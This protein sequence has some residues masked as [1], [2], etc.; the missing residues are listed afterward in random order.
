MNEPITCSSQTLGQ[1]FNLSQRR[2]RM[3][4]SQGILVKQQHG[5]Y[6]LCESLRGYITFLKGC[7]TQAAK[8]QQ[9]GLHAGSNPFCQ[10]LAR[11]ERKLDQLVRRQLG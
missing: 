3:L 4:A 5:K 7:R 1:L 11:I 10:R 8:L 6:D 2:I 9:R